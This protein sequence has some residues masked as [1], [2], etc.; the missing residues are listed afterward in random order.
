MEKPNVK[1]LRKAA[2]R[3]TENIYYMGP[4]CYAWAE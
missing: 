4:L 2:N 1:I 3:F